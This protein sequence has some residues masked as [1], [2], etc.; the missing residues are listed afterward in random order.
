[1]NKRRGFIRSREVLWA[2]GA[3]VALGAT[4][5]LGTLP[6]TL[7][8]YFGPGTQPTEINEYMLSANDCSS[9]HG[10]FNA[11]QEPFRPW[12]ASL[13]GQAMRDPVFHAALA[14]A[15]ADAD[16]AG[17]LCLRCH[18]PSGWVEGRS[19]PTDGSAMS[20]TDLE[21]VT[22]HTCHRMVDPVYV[23]GQSPPDDQKILGNLTFPP[24]SP[25]SGHYI[26][27]PND[28]R[29]GPFSLPGFTFHQWR[30]SP[31]HQSATMCATCHDVSNP[32]YTRQPGGTYTL[33]ELG[34][35]HPTSNVYDE[36]PLER[37]YSEW[38][39]SAFA[40]APINMGGRFGGNKLEVSTC[41]DCHMPDATGKACSFGE[42]R[43]DLPPHHFNGGN[44]WVLKAVRNLYNDGDTFLSASTVDASIARTV[45]MLKKAGD[46]ALSATAATLTARITNESG[47]KLP[48]GYPE[49]RRIWINVR[50]MNSAGA[51]IAERGAYNAAT[52]ELTTADTKVYEGKL[53]LDAAVSAA[54][55]VPEGESFHFVLNNVWLKD[56]RIPPRGF[57]NAGF[58]AVQAAP[59]AATYADGQNWDDT[60]FAIPP[61]ART[62]EVRVYYQSTSK[63]YIE[64]LRDK[65]G[66]KGQIAYDQWAL[67]GR[68]APVEMDLGTIQLCEADCNR[69][70][71]LNLADFGCFQTKFALADP[72]ADCNK[73]GALNLSDFGCFMT[74]FA[75]GCP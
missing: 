32:V 16:F 1:M 23:A 57:T 36:F 50:F 3:I 9:C 58:A 52:G 42:V 73:D 8:D 47:H 39:A 64:F 38:S 24:D 11:V 54:T 48:S 30:K 15:N 62:A 69:D 43:S 65:G 27:D 53:G 34:A 68:S 10:G 31:F 41:Q 63:E 61:T 17:D 19:V 71:V 6:T 46:L 67:L 21:G 29:R 22:C 56:N 70:G 2:G 75:L 14:V 51:L 12:A 26:I 37:T 7:L 66:A 60:A 33:N 74:K 72:V 45:D 13:M 35:A 55:G 40:V 28:R 20:G 59:V 4:A 25:H 44:T 18:A 5:T 49:G